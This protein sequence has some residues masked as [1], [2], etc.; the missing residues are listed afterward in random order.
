MQEKE[1]AGQIINML[2]TGNYYTECPDCGETIMLRNAHLFPLD[3]FNEKAKE[4]YKQHQLELKEI[5]G[6]L[7]RRKK[8]IIEGSRT[9]AKATNIGF[10]LEQIAPSLE[11]FPFCCNDCRSLFDPIDYVVFEGLSNAGVVK[12]IFWVEIKTGSRPRLERHESQ[13]KRLVEG[14]KLEWDTYKEEED[15]G[16]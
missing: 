2:T 3:N 4:A 10:I 6:E 5:R 9:K 14:K 15:N 7:K 8:I 11:D 16:K 1:K 13:V 12:K